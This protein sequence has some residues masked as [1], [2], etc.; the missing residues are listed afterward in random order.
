MYILNCCKYKGA[1]IISII[2][3]KIR[4]RVD[5]KLIIAENT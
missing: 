5:Q 1:K 2:R 3:V 4:F